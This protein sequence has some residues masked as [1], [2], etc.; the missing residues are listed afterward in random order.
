MVAFTFSHHRKKIIHFGNVFMA[1]EYFDEPTNYDTDLKC[2]T[3]EG[4]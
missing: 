3:R 4:T 1:N 2:D